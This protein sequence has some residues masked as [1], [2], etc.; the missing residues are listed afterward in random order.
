MGRLTREESREITRKKLRSAAIGEIAATGFGGASID[1]ICEF[2]G[3]SRGAFYA[4]F[5]SKEEL[6]LDIMRSFHDREAE[7]WIALINSD[8]SLDELMPQLRERF[9]AYLADRSRI[10]FTSEIFLYAKRNQGFMVS[11]REEFLAVALGA[12]RVLEAIF[13][14]AGKS[15]HRPFA[16]LASLMRG[17]FT[18]IA[19]VMEVSSGES[20]HSPDVLL[21]FLEDILALGQ[22]A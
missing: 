12:E 3:F 14:K 11:Y 2:A 10:L 18:G 9:S 1:R 16:E 5:N 21:I 8:I 6:L 20:V 15:P 7:S 17:L 4:N 22:A 13:R 19:L